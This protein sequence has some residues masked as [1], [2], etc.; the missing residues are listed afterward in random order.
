MKH[1]H[2]ITLTL[3]G[4]VLGGAVCAVAD[5][6]APQRAFVIACA[7]EYRPVAERLAAHVA[8][9]PLLKVFAEH[10]SAPEILPLEDL[11]APRLFGHLVLIGEPSAPRIAQAWQ[12]EAKMLPDGGFYVF[13]FGYFK[14]D[15]G[16]VESGRNPFLYGRESPKPRP[17]HS[18]C[19]V[20]S[21]NTAAGIDAAARAFLEKSLL[22]GVVSQNAVRLKPS[23]LER[24]PVS[25]LAEFD[26]PPP[27]PEGYAYLGV[28]LP[29]EMEYRNALEALE[30]LPKKSLRYKYHR[31]GGFPLHADELTESFALYRNGLHRKA[32]ANTLLVMTFEDA[33][34]AQKAFTAFSRATGLRDGKGNQPSLQPGWDPNPGSPLR[35]EVKDA[36]L[37]V[38]T[39][40]D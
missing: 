28:T 3:L 39:L 25:E 22:N 4:T 20:I 1:A 24:A 33:A 27:P 5:A 17:F 6:A 12:Q 31:P 21:G 13:G 29:S 23:L 34:A 10:S 32:V 37:W 14:G 18:E 30:M 9:H 16:F 26:A 15:I 40:E 35:A 36:Q 2:I 19:V 38:S 8:E 11:D 7:A